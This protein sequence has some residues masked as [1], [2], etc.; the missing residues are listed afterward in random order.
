MIDNCERDLQNLQ[1]PS[2]CKKCAKISL[3]LI[4]QVQLYCAWQKECLNW[5]IFRYLI[6]YPQSICDTSWRSFCGDE[7]I[8]IHTRSC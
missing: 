3:Q 6:T 4:L 8:C 7:H 1:D 5:P 2:Y